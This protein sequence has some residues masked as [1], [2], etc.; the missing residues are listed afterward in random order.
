MPRLHVFTE[1]RL[2]IALGFKAL[3]IHPA[4]EISNFLVRSSQRERGFRC[5]NSDK[6]AL[7]MHCR[8]ACGSGVKRMQGGK[9]GG[10]CWFVNGFG[11]YGQCDGDEG[12]N[13]V[14]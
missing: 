4:T 3:I 8:L 14:S 10:Y 7:L 6:K 12:Q 11:N 5:Q 2:L 1:F 13:P 9:E